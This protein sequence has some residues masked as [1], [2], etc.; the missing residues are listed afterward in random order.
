MHRKDKGD[1]ILGALSSDNDDEQTASLNA[2]NLDLCSFLLIWAQAP[3]L[4]IVMSALRE[5]P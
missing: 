4:E 1:D 3:M 5:E 2:I